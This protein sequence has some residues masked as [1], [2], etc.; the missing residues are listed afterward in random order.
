MDADERRCVGGRNRASPGRWPSGWLAHGTRHGLPA[1]Q[2]YRHAAGAESNL[3]ARGAMVSPIARDDVHDVAR[4]RRRW[5]RP[6]EPQRAGRGRG[7]LLRFG[8]PDVERVAVVVRLQSF[9]RGPTAADDHRVDRPFEPRTS[10]VMKLGPAVDDHDERQ[11]RAFQGWRG[12]LRQQE[13]ER[14]EQRH[15]RRG[16]PRRLSFGRRCN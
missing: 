16:R 8:R 6:G 12:C 4:R 11:A 15:H 13:H 10:G 7:L 1:E 14:E 2:F 5:N 9:R 3:R